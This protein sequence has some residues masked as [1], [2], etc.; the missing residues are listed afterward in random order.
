MLSM[1]SSTHIYSTLNHL[2][3]VNSFRITN[4]TWKPAN[5]TFEFWY[6]LFQAQM[7]LICYVGYICASIFAFVELKSL[8][9]CR[10]LKLSKYCRISIFT[11]FGKCD[12]S[13]LFLSTIWELLY[14][15]MITSPHN[16]QVH[17]QLK[18]FFTSW[19]QEWCVDI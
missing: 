9:M 1:T 13:K 10:L 5:S 7:Y 12:F 18:L 17:V 2:S 6:W 4:K 14:E 11:C 16:G 15:N 19:L 3:Q 8:M